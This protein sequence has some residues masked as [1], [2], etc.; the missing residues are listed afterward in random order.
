MTTFIT[1]AFPPL[2]EVR[3][4][5]RLVTR[6]VPEVTLAG[7]R[8]IVHDIRPNYIQPG[9]KVLEHVHS[10]YEGHILLHGSALYTMGET[11][12]MEEGGTL[13][14]GPHTTHAWR[15]AEAPC[16]R[17]LIWF[18]MEPVVA[19][20]R[21]AFWPV[22]PD[23]IWDIALLLHDA[24]EM[25]P[26]WQDRT[27]ARLAVVL[28][29]LLSIANWPANQLATQLPRTHLI[30]V[31][32]QFLLD[33]LAR[34][35]TLDDIATHVGLSQRSLCRQFL[36]LTGTTV[37]EHLFN[38]RMDYAA[39]QLAETDAPVYEIGEKVGMPDPSYFCRRFRRHFHLTPQV[40]RKQ[41]AAGIK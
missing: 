16:L 12:Y 35:L 14:H 25:S 39:E 24:G 28:S 17:L 5:C 31:I 40:Y 3:R 22:W 34:P 30:S 38:L 32:D 15:E 26:G 8:L 9:R 13:L 10:F 18:S 19:V 2:S 21:P 20:P 37:M 27:T 11:Q 23:L 41:V 7:H 29:R 33:N 6:T 4:L 36:N 1:P